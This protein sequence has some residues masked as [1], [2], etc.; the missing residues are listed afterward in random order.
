[1][2]SNTRSPTAPLASSYLNRKL[3]AGDGTAVVE[4]D[5]SVADRD[6]YPGLQNGVELHPARHAW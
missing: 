6:R 4:C 3:A 2:K 5:A 1:M